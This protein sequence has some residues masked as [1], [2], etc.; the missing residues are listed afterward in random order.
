MS[1]HIFVLRF[2][3]ILYVVHLKASSLPVNLKFLETDHC[4]LL[5]DDPELGGSN[6]CL[7]IIFVGTKCLTSLIHIGKLGVTWKN[8]LSSENLVSRMLS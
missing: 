5:C 4:G 2:F 7:V 1:C 3:P 6:P 8:W